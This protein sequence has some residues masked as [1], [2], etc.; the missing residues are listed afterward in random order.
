ME[1]SISEADFPKIEAEM[2][3][4]IKEDEP[5]ERIEMPREKAVALCEELGQSLKVEHIGDTLA[6]LGR[7][8][9]AMAAYRRSLAQEPDNPAV[10]DKL[11]KLEE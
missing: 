2:A 11:R 7:F 4:I 3:R 10:R 9:E 5:F 1:H 8:P 6:A